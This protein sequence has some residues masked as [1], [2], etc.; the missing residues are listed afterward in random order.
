MAIVR[1]RQPTICIKLSRI[2]A[3]P[4]T[5]CWTCWKKL[6]ANTKFPLETDSWLCDVELRLN[7]LCFFQGKTRKKKSLYGFSFFFRASVPHGTPSQFGWKGQPEF[8]PLTTIV[9]SLLSTVSYK[10]EGVFRSVLAC[11]RR[12]S[13]LY[14]QQHVI[15]YLQAALES[16]PL[17]LGFAKRSEVFER[18]S[19]EAKGVFEIEEA[20]K[21]AA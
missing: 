17:A 11:F 6:L 7:L 5:T 2:I 19:I 18:L 20:S 1:K 13:A 8:D 4:I 16:L 3:N 21:P 10:N 14:E 12:A 15:P 9:L